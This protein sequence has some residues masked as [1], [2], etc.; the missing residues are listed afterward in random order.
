M[1]NRFLPAVL[2]AA[3]AVL[4]APFALP[5]ECGDPQLMTD[6]PWYP[7]ELSCST[8]P[9]LFKTQ[10][11]VYKRVT[12][13]S[14]DTDQDKVLASWYWRN[15]HYAHCEEGKPDL[16]G[17]GKREWNRNYWTGLFAYGFGLCGTTHCQYAA[18]MNE[19]LGPSRGRVAGVDGH[20]SFEA[21]LTGG[22][23]GKGDWVILDHDQSTVIFSDDGSRLLGFKAIIAGDFKNYINQKWKPERQQGWLVAGL[24]PNDDQDYDKFSVAEYDSGYAGPPPMVHLRAGESLRRYLEPGL[25]DGKTF[26]YWGLNCNNDGIPGP[27]RPETWVNQPEKMYKATASTSATAKGGQARFANAVYTYKPDFAK[28]GYKEGVVD[29]DKDQVTFEFYTPYVVACT[30]TDKSNWG[31]YNKGSKNGLVLHGKFTCPVSVSVDQGKTWQ[32]AGAGQ[33]GLDLTDMVKGHDQ[34]LLKL[35]ADAQ[36]LAASGLTIVTVCEC[37]SA[38]IPRLHDG[39]NKITFEASGQGLLN[40]GPNID[41]AEPHVVDGAMGSNKVTLKLST[42]RKEKIAAIYGQS[43][44]SS[45][46]P[47]KPDVKYQIE[48]SADDGKTWAPVVKDFTVICRDPE[49]GDWWSQ[50][51]CWGNTAVKEQVDTVQVRFSNSG[52]KQYRKV[53]AYLAYKVAKQGP[54]DVT[55]C[56]SENKAAPKTAT[57]TFA[58]TPGQADKAWSVKTGS[59]VKTLWVEYA[60]K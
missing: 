58:A 35:G 41:Q 25:E 10:A 31:I 40:A 39:D 46:C 49:P 13:K 19:L 2:C 56:W 54:C 32:D 14:V 11:D 50:S 20:N 7:G 5:A 45:G 30:P 55:F 47:P 18:E 53:E 42:P 28:G 44:Q 26:V 38:I 36:A 21:Y 27:A 59:A 22:A 6:D 15:L 1:A 16:F 37:N 9:R 24:H 4:L 33:D 57:H 29:E 48:Y 8:F 12:G 3:F 17:P 34:Y 52:G 51:L 60:C 23:Y 43:W